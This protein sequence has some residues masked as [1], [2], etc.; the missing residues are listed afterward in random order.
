MEN[1]K[2]DEIRQDVET[3]RRTAKPPPTKI[4][5]SE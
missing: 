3:I 2:V 5:P 4:T 1:L